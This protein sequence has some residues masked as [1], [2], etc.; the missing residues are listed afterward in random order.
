MRLASLLPK[1]EGRRLLDAKIEAVRVTSNLGRLW[2]I[3]LASYSGNVKL[4]RADKPKQEVSSFCCHPSYYESGVR[5]DFFI[6]YLAQYLM[7][8]N[9]E[10]TFVNTGMAS[11]NRIFLRHRKPTAAE[12]REFHPGKMREHE[13]RCPQRRSE[14]DHCG[15]CHYCTYYQN[16]NRDIA[17]SNELTPLQYCL[18]KRREIGVDT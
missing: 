18:W 4:M 7:L 15:K 16:L 9:D 6:A 1:P 8:K 2:V 17:R 12:A 13:W 14:D 3:S 10:D 5:D 11:Y